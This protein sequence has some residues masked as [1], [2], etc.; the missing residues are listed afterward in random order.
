MQCDLTY[1]Y[2]LCCYFYRNF[3]NKLWNAGKYINNCLANSSAPTSPTTTTSLRDTADSTAST[4]Q[5]LAVTGPMTQQELN[6]LSVPE[7]YIV[8]RCH[9]V[10]IEVTKL[11]EALSFSDAG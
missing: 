7:R 3:A 11:L 9:E 1:M 5:E 8:S 10:V 2:Q 6:A 4:S